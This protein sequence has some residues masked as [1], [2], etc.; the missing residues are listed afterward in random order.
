MEE[1]AKRL[2]EFG[3][4]RVD[5]VERVLLC[6]GESVALTSKLFDI[7]LLLVENNGHVVDKER[8]MKEVWPDTFVEEGNLTQNVSLLRKALGEKPGGP[9]F[10]ETVAR[11]GYRFVAAVSEARD[12]ETAQGPTATLIAARL[13]AKDRTKLESSV[14]PSA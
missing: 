12:G 5:P 14:Q 8:L 10:I 7:L 9:Q 13:S 4:F 2:F 3:P 1:H 11:R 6:E